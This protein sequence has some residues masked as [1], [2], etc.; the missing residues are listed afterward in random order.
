MHRIDSDGHINN[1]FNEGDPST[2]MPAT[3]ISADWLNA[4]QEEL[5]NALEGAGVPLNKADNAQLAAAFLGVELTPGGTILG[6]VYVRRMGKTVTVHGV[7]TNV[8]GSVAVDGVIVNIPAGYRPAA[9]LPQNPAALAASV[10]GAAF[11]Q[12][13]GINAIRVIREG[14]AGAGDLRWMGPTAFGGLVYAQFSF[15]YRCD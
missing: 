14:D 5:V 11:S 4:V 8:G 12:A 9:G 6:K 13:Q 1:Q 15:S 2:G 3:E 10:S 7:L